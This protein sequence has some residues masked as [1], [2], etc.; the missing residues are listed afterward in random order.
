MA[1][2]TD[3]DDAMQSPDGPPQTP[4][5]PHTATAAHNTFDYLYEFSETR[6]VLE[7]FFKPTENS[8]VSPQPFQV[9][10]DPV[11][12]YFVK[13]LSLS[14]RKSGVNYKTWSLC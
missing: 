7:E 9:P 10:A 1:G 14:C 4:T 12:E 3:E 11:I 8:E 5:P 2:G 6:K 13:L